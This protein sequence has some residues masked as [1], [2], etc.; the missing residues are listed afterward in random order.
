MSQG[1]TDSDPT[2]IRFRFAVRAVLVQL[3][4]IQTLLGLYALFI[5]VSFYEDFPFGRGWVEAL[6]AY[7]EHLVRDVGGLFLGTG[8]LLI[9][10]GYWMERRWIGVALV[11]FLLFSVPH[12][13]WHLFNLE[14]YST[15]DAIGNA[16]T[17]TATV[18]L[19]LWALWAT[20]SA[21]G[22]GRGAD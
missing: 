17:L 3:G 21:R 20:F 11:S 19:P 1:P 16:V 18:L 14:P 22:S 4:A 7:N 8:F 15:G 6:P 2:P 5:P 9:A 10:A 13:V 12:T